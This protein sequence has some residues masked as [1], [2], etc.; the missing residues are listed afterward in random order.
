VIT[1][2]ADSA[3]CTLNTSAKRVKKKR[4]MVIWVPFLFGSTKK[5]QVIGKDYIDYLENESFSDW[6]RR[7]FRIS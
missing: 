4:G 7:F 6:L 5:G 3:F 2:S 1:V